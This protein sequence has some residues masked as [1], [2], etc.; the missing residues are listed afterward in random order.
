MSSTHQPKQNIY[1]VKSRAVGKR[2][3]HGVKIIQWQRTPSK[4]LKRVHGKFQ[5]T[6]LY[7]AAVMMKDYLEQ[8]S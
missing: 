3:G 4:N 5:H 7:Q 8:D 6:K 1:P 2:T